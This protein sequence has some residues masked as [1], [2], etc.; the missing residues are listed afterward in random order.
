MSLIFIPTISSHKLHHTQF[1]NKTST[2]LSALT[3]GEI[4]EARVIEKLSDRNILIMLKG[5]KMPADSEV[6]LNAGEKLSV[7]VES[8]HPQVVLRIVG[9]ADPE[10]SRIADYLR[11]FR[12]NPDALSQLITEAVTLFNVGNLGNIVRYFPGEDLQRISKMLKLL[13]LSPESKGNNFV[14]DYISNL[15]LLTESQLRKILE[16]K[17]GISEGDFQPQNLKSLLINLSDD[18][19]NL[20][21]KKEALDPETVITLTKLSEYVDSALKTIESH[22][23][24]NYLLQ[25]AESKYLFQLP[26]LFPDGVRKGDIFVEYD[27]DKRKGGHKGQF[28][29]IV[30]LNMDILGE[31]IIE[32]KLEGNTIG[33]LIKCKDQEIC[34]LVS[35]FLEEL[36]K[37]LLAAG[38]E[39]NAVTCVAGGDLVAEKIDY[40]RDR[41]LYA[42][43]IIDLLV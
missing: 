1:H 17:A 29:A 7:K 4:L 10:E 24:I 41:V 35:S 37:N 15:G 20:L 39:I 26:I 40:Y 31:M 23:I 21:M 3:I 25:E 27:R 33:C 13:F 36:R 43:G 6:S 28:R 42:R 14:R 12:A 30:F 2:G 19:Q 5:I 9:G 18:I 38:C 16:G 8:L 32:A 34:D 22:Q 11:C